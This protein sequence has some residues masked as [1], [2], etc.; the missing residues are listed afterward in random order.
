MSI[1]TD[2]ELLDVEA[3]NEILDDSERLRQ[4][5]VQH[6]IR[7]VPLDQ[8]LE[9]CGRNWLPALMAREVNLFILLFEKAQ[10][11][12]LILMYALII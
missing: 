11:D 12:A 7:Q 3:Q 10:K 6:K 9:I 1:S 2:S 8:L 4:W 5:S